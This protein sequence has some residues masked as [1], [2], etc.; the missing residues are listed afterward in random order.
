M[1]LRDTAVPWRT[2]A[3]FWSNWGVCPR[4]KDPFPSGSYG[5]VIATGAWVWPR[6]FLMRAQ[7]WLYR[8]EQA[9]SPNRLSR[10]RP[11][12]WARRAP[13]HALKLLLKGC[14][15]LSATVETNGIPRYPLKA[16]TYP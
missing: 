3:G 7:R 15:S 11:Q 2:Q 4:R 6:R 1:T 12:R 5:I 16:K 10:T 8:S 9:V 14:I 13:D